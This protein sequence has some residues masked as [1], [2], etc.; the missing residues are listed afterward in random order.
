MCA[1]KNWRKKH[2]TKAEGRKECKNQWNWE[3]KV[4]KK[5]N[6]AKSYLFGKVNRTGKLLVRQTKKKTEETN[7]TLPECR[8]G[9]N[10]FHITIMLGLPWG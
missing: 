8:R 1:L 6:E 4:E 10:T 5:I 7:W 2:P 9:A 3:Q